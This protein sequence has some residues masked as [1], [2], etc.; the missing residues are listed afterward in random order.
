MNKRQKKKFKR[1]LFFKTYAFR[2]VITPPNPDKSNCINVD[3]FHNGKFGGVLRSYRIVPEEENPGEYLLGTSTYNE[4]WG[5]VM[6]SCKYSSR[7]R[8]ILAGAVAKYFK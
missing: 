2:T 7:I 5:R 3:I 4:R 6:N 1:K 8:A